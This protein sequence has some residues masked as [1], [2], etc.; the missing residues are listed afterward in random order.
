MI[1]LYVL[2][3]DDYLLYILS[4]F[5]GSK[6]TDFFVR[7][8]I[9]PSTF[10]RKFL[11]FI[12]FRKSTIIWLTQDERRRSC[13]QQSCNIWPVQYWNRTLLLG[14]SFVLASYL[15]CWFLRVGYHV[16]R[17]LCTPLLVLWITF[18]YPTSREDNIIYK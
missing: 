7:F 8:V 15:K 4:T 17:S 2:L 5:V 11:L 14:N 10:P 1:I 3:I 13:F 12:H 16:P 18:H 9:F 6:L